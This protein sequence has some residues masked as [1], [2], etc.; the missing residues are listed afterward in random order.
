MQIAH[1]YTKFPS[2]Q[3]YEAY[4]G[5]L[6]LKD[7]SDLNDPWQNEHVSSAENTVTDRSGSGEI[8]V[9]EFQVRGAFYDFW[10]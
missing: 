5:D 2:V 10:N 3:H 8:D 9:P 6:N 1:L 7:D 4:V